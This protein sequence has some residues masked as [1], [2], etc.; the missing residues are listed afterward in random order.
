LADHGELEPAGRQPGQ[1]RPD[2]LLAL[3]VAEACATGS[4]ARIMSASSS[5]RRW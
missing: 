4:T 5:R 1:Q 2:V 3:L